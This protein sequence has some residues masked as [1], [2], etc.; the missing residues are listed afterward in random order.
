[1]ALSVREVR[2]GHPE[3][4][5]HLGVQFVDLG[6][7]TIGGQPFRQ[8]VG[9]Q[10]CPIDPLGLGAQDAVQANGVCC[11]DRLGLGFFGHVVSL[12][13]E[14]ESRGFQIWQASLP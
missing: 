8:S 6:R 5:T 7:E 14:G 13:C 11:S 12:C 9:I 1:M 2:E 3:C 4:S 10:E